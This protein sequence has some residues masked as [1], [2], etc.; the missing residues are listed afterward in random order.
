ML[1]SLCCGCGAVTKGSEECANGCRL[2]FLLLADPCPPPPDPIPTPP[3]A[4]QQPPLPPEGQ[5][6]G[7]ARLA[8]GAC[9][10]CSHQSV[11][12]R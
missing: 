8:E 4:S 10:E 9:D 3:A 11:E 6:D 5:G 2:S 1:C 12:L 7:G